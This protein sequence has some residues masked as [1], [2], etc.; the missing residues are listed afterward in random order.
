MVHKIAAVASAI[1]SAAKTPVTPI[2]FDS[3]KTRG[4]NKNTLRN[5]AINKDTLACPNARNM[6]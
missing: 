4:T 3:I 1:D 6:L 5:S 2:N